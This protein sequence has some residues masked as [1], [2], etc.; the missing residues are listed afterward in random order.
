MAVYPFQFLLLSLT[1]L[2][3]YTKKVG[4]LSRWRID[5]SY[6]LK[7]LKSASP[8]IFS[9]FLIMIYT[10]TDQL[11]IASFMGNESLGVY[12]SSARLAEL[13]AFL[14]V[15]IVNSATPNL[16][17]AKEKGESDYYKLLEKV[18]ITLVL[19]SYV[20]GLATV[21]FASNIILIL[22]GKDFVTGV[23]VLNILIW[24]ICFISLG[25]I[26]TTHVTIKDVPIISLIA[27]AFGAI[28]NI[29]LNLFL[30]PNFGIAGAAWATLI[31]QFLASFL[32]SIFFVETRELFFNQ[33]RALLL[34]DLFLLLRRRHF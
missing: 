11:M 15:S 5:F 19:F 8:L 18:T 25:L 17:R 33:L 26:R 2:A 28:L 21:S 9:G 14:P 34:T 4:E 29:V 10:R 27:T 20:L 24:V 32:A 31:S 7:L 23:I 3:I 13:W 12:A 6:A 1:F 30:I 16:A 22:Y